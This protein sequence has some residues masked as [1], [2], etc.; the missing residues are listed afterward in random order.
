MKCKHSLIEYCFFTIDRIF[1]T[2][3]MVIQSE[4][5]LGMKSDKQTGCPNLSN[6]LSTI[7]GD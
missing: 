5:K 4:G 6:W 3:E 2:V 7:I 1:G